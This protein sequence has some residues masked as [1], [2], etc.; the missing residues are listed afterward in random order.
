MVVFCLKLL[1][2]TIFALM[3]SFSHLF[4]CLTGFKFSSIG[5]AFG[6][7]PWRSTGYGI[8]RIPC[9]LQND[10]ELFPQMTDLLREG[11]QH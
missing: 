6:E 1:C 7:V 2:R 5:M 3:M 9:V 11:F 4:D 8:H 10:V